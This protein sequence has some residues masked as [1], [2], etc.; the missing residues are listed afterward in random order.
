L[1]AIAVT[2]VEGTYLATDHQLGSAGLAQQVV[3][4]DEH[5]QA[6]DRQ[7]PKPPRQ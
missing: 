1:Q 5:D 6:E 2:M 4:P 7:S 3:E